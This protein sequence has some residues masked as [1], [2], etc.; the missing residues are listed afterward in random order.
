MVLILSPKN[1]LWKVV[2]ALLIAIAASV[3]LLNLAK[4]K[5]DGDKTRSP[6]IQTQLF[7]SPQ[8][9]APPTKAQPTVPPPAGWKKI[10]GNSVE[11][12]LPPGYEGGNP[13]QNLEGKLNKLKAINPDYKKVIEAI[14]LN[15]T[16]ALV[17]FELP[18]KS[19]FITNVNVLPETVTAGTEVEQYLQTVTQEISNQYKVVDQKVV[20]LNSYRAVRLV[21]EAPA[22]NTK[23]KQLL[24]AIPQG[25]TFWLVTFSTT[26][27][28]FEQRLPT[29]EKSVRT[30]TM[31]RLL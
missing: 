27:E 2:A 14:K 11:I 13:S 16:L 22:G 15:P 26:V 31:S 1:I 3:A 6:N 23:V 20:S 29:F 25:N 9:P 12:W 18:P 28:E 24:Y 30:L 7:Q 21:A 10:A 5:G 4:Q 17:A 19:A 8:A